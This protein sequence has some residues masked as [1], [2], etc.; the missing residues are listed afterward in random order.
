VPS[1][2][3]VRQA[4]LGL[5]AGTGSLKGGLFTPGGEPLGLATET[6]PLATPEPGAMEQDPAHWWTALAAVSR[7]LLDRA[8]PVQLLAVAIS[9]QA[10]TLVAVD[11]DLLPTH[12]AITWLDKRQATEAER[13]Y[14]LLGQSVPTWGSWPAQVAWFAHERP[15]AMRRTRWLLGCP[16][17]LATRLTGEPVLF[18]AWAKPELEA[19]EVDQRLLPPVRPP[20]TIVGSVTP[21]AA[22][23]TGLPAGTP[24]VAGFIDG[25]M[26]VLGSGAQSPGDACLNSGTSGTFSVLGPPGAGYAVLDLHIMGAAT[27]TSGK[28]LDWFAEHIARQPTAYTQ[29]IEEAAA[30]PA[31]ARGLLFLPH[32]AGER[33]A[34]HDARSRGAWVGLTLE[35]DRRHLLRALLEGVA[36]SF[37][38]VQEWLADSG[39]EI[40]DVHCVGGQARSALWNQIKADVL[41][42][43]VLVP[44]VV[45]AAVVGSAI[46]ATLALGVQPNRE[47]AVSA[48]I[49]VAER[50]DPEP[51]SA[52]LYDELYAEFTRLYPALRQTNWRLDS[53]RKTRA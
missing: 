23:D 39:A 12:P 28:A 5:D 48:M 24:V 2:P 42:R 30:V 22:A 3:L 20:S 46:L 45:E 7:Q 8:G 52:R 10:P 26:G 27:N 47:A 21:A 9:G 1:E 41:N 38:S 4:V 37:R 33:A 50:F 25:V 15:A 40:R 43:R 35:H 29:L 32:L 34:V 31:G 16:D 44:E 13:L 11:A 36:F 19:A 6:Y 49:R 14:A 53:F 17:Y 51:R 18:L